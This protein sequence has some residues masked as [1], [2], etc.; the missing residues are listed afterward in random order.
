MVYRNF[1]KKN[2]L[3]ENEVLVSDLSDPI[4]AFIGDIFKKR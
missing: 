2:I 4:Y 1:S 3:G